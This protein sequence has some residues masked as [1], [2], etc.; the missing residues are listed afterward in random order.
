M[1]VDPGVHEQQLVDRLRRQRRA[2]RLGRGELA[3][4]L[5]GR[6]LGERSAA[7]L[8]LDDDGAGADAPEGGP[9]A[10]PRRVDQHEVVALRG[11]QP[12]HAARRARQR[13]ALVLQARRLFE[14][15]CL[16]EHRL[17]L[18]QAP[19]EVVGVP[20]QHAAHVRDDGR[21]LAVE[22][23]A[24]RRQ[25]GARAGAL[26]GVL[27]PAS[28]QV[29][30]GAQRVG[31]VDAV[32]EAPG[33]AGLAEGPGVV[34][35]V[36]AQVGRGVEPRVLLRAELHVVVAG[37]LGAVR[38]VRR[39]VPRDQAALEQERGELG[40]GLDHVDALEQL[41]RL[42]GVER[43]PLQEVVARAPPQVLGLADVQRRALGVLHQVHA[44]GGRELLGER[45]LVVVAP[46]RGLAEARDLLERVHA[47]LL[48]PREEQQEQLAGGLRVV[49][50]AVHRLDPGVEAVGEG[51]ERTALLRAELARQAQG[52]ERGPRERLPA[53]LAQLV[54][55]EPE[56]ERR[57]V[58]HQHGVRGEVDE[59]GQ[60]DLDRR[61]PGDGLV[62][63][64][65]DAGDHGGDRHARVDEGGERG[66]LAPALDAHGAD[67][68]DL[69]EA[70]RGAGGLDV[71]DGEGHVG[72]V[73]APR[74]PRREPDV[75]VALPQE[76]LVALDDVGDELAHEL[77]RAVGDG[78]EARPHLAVVEGFAG[79]LEQA[80]ELIDGGERQLHA[81][82]LCPRADGCTGGDDAEP[83]L[84]S[85]R[86]RRY[87]PRANR[88][89]P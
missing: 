64:A 17:A 52:V 67:L 34:R 84:R 25:A 33:Q 32:D 48:Q 66:D 21:V 9:S 20:L 35:A 56:V 3:E 18:D 62:V 12:A 58:G 47:L 88:V 10:P 22:R 29:G 36:V 46:G 30:A 4:Q 39:P 63:D 5:P 14:R 28:R 89:G 19:V 80:L 68:G 75:D 72:E 42:P 11:A 43:L 24:A 40:A 78:E 69:A 71:D 74:P 2:R 51:A 83:G 57:V 85:S 54:V 77:G 1:R 31:A 82:I 86:V 23:P 41:E 60:H 55:E 37:G 70:R 26:A 73:A 45:D 76:A 13:L 50:G 61:R 79:L 44:R 15:E 81:I 38:V 53:L 7:H 59:L 27:A 16:D 8:A 6:L 65:G 49:Q 87:A